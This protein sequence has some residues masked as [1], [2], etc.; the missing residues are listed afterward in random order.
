MIEWFTWL[1][2]AIAVAAGVLC[3]VVGLLGRAPADLTMGATLLVELILVGQI[4]VSAVA[5]ALGN[6]PTGSLLEFW[7]YLITAMLIPP[8]AIIWG[9]V[10][11]SRWST[12][13]LGAG[14]IAVAIMLYR[15]HAI[16][17]AQVA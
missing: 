15:M 8:L 2:I 13:I 11:R 17:F 12:V 1:Q 9:L 6:V 16:W 14:S 7:L 10:E 3:I 5:P 4:L